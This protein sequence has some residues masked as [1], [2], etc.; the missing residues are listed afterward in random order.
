MDQGASRYIISY[1]T[2]RGKVRSNITDMRGGKG[3]YS[4]AA[5]GIEAAC[6]RENVNLEEHGRGGTW[7]GRS[8]GSLPEGGYNLRLEGEHVR[9][10]I[11]FFTK[12]DGDGG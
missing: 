3:R 8:G 11:H 5:D 2:H 12:S 9:W 6:G 4:R 7:A 1:Y 10:G